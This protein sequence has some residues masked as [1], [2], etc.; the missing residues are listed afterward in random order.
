MKTLKFSLVLRTRENTAVF[1]TLDE[2]IYG[3]HSK[4]TINFYLSSLETS[5]AGKWFGHST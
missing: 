3:I 5:N 1:I 4:R 2:N